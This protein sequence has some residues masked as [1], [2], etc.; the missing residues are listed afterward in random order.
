[1][2]DIDN[3]AYL[4]IFGSIIRQAILD[5]Q[6]FPKKTVEYNEVESYLFSKNGLEGYLQE[7]GIDDL[8]SI[9]YIRKIAKYDKID[10][11]HS[12]LWNI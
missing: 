4:Q 2:N 9:D 8:V 11:H 3:Y 7:L 6:S 10:Y 5:Y 1:M 12:V